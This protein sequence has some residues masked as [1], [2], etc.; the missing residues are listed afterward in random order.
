MPERRRRG[1]R[2]EANAGFAGDHDAPK[3]I[4]AGMKAALRV[5]KRGCGR[6]SPNPIVG[7]AVAIPGQ[8]LVVAWHAK[9]GSSHAEVRLLERV[10]PRGALPAGSTLY[11]TL[12]PCS[13]QGK[14]PP[15]ADRVVESRPAR[16]VVA[17]LDP[18]PQVAG[19]GVAHLRAAGLE[20]S[21]GPGQDEALAANLPFHLWHRLGRALCRLKVASSLD[22]RLG[23]ASGKDRR[24]TGDLAIN[25]VHRERAASDA[26]LVGS[27]TMA[28]DDPLLTVRA[29]RGPD[30]SRIVVDSGLRTAP[31]CRTWRA[32]VE[33]AALS[34]GPAARTAPA[35]NFWLV[36]ARPG[37][38]WERR[39]RLV[40][41]TRVGH[42]MRRLDAYR[43]L[44]WEV[45][46]LPLGRRGSAGEGRVSLPALAIRAGQ[47]GF[48]RVLVEAGPRLAGAL[49]AADLVDELSLYL[50]PILLGGPLVWPAGWMARGP[51]R[52]VRFEPVAATVLGGDRHLLLRRV[53]LLERVRWGGE[54]GAGG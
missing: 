16:V 48:R 31:R 6:V 21:V 51:S 3:I 33:E 9:F 29:V 43:R 27:G 11:V 54:Q 23:G 36:A 25:S 52:R 15:C 39:A 32:W 35:G 19:R 50:A 46:E 37:P 47:E 24:V 22:A 20:V 12:E 53:G 26:I 4:P 17:C 2:L 40:I 38:R 30:P 7:A 14:T 18:D 8:D 34:L 42:P 1:V 10:A 5:A 44:G 28:A 13:H 49:V 41:A 45:W